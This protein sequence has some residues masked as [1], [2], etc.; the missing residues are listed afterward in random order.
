MI[1]T[2]AALIAGAV[3]AA[4]SAAYS[5]YVQNDNAIDAKK[6]ADIQAAQVRDQ[7]AKQADLIRQRGDRVRAAQAASL[8]GSGVDLNSGTSGALFNETNR[9]TEQDALATLTT[10]E[11]QADALERGGNF[12]AVA[13]T[14]AAVGQ[15][16]GFLGQ[17]LR[18]YQGYVGSGQ[19]S[20]FA[21]QIT[22]DANSM[23]SRTAPKY[24]LLNGG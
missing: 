17:G 6:N 2:T 13:G 23:Y 20:A 16:L 10:G 11:R 22:M 15:G 1:G 8:A 19:N 9:L 12:A 5:G 18:T 4:G 14:S 7:A 24:S 21:S 3:V